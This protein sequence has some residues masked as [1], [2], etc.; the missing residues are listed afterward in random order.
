MLRILY[1]FYNR[2]FSERIISMG[3]FVSGISEGFDIIDF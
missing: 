1:C 3:F 2:I